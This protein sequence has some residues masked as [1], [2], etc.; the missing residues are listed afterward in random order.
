MNVM[1]II[2]GALAGLV[3]FIWLTISWMALPFHGE[4]LSG[5]KHDA[6]IDALLIQHGAKDGLNYYPSYE[7]MEQGEYME[8]AKSVPNIGIMSFSAG[9]FDMSN[10]WAY[11]R[12]LLGCIVAGILVAIFVSVLPAGSSRAGRILFCTLFGAAAFFCTQWVDGGFYHFPMRHTVLQLM[13]SMVSWTL[14]G[15]VL[16]FMVRPQGAAADR[17]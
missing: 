4:S 17:N 10:P 16:A 14:A 5:I 1:N 7:G 9:G 8:L 6:Q 13:D 15:V 2:A 3:I 12:G 11:I